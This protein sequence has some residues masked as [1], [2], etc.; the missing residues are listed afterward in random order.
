[1]QVF[2][3]DVD[4]PIIPPLQSKNIMFLD[5]ETNGLSHKHKLVI[6]GLVIY[7]PTHKSGK[8][9]QLFNDD[10]TS[11]RDMLDELRSL[12]KVNAIDYFVSFNGNAFDF[13]FLNARYAHYKIDYVL[14]KAANIDILRIARV[15][16]KDLGLSDLKLKTVERAVGIDRTDVISG[17]DSIVLYDAYLESRSEA[18]KSTI[19]LHNFDDLANM[20]PLLELTKSIPFNFPDYFSTRGCKIYLSSAK[21]RGSKLSCTLELSSRLSIMDLFYESSEIRFK[22]S[23]TAIAL[24][25][26]CIH[27]KDAMDNTYHFIYSMLVEEMPFDAASDD[28]KRIHLA[29][30]NKEQVQNQASSQI[31][32]VCNALL[33]LLMK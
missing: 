23:G 14:P 2:I 1:M 31:F 6:I 10:F 12:I 4:I 17:K 19:L 33:D 3:H 13:P 11:E 29:F 25:I 21:L 7:T 9:I 30:V 22:C 20:V 15:H 24:D 5:I 32:R 27:M 26:D 28:E 16:Q 8:L 18:L